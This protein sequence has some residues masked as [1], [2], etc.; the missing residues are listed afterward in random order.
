MVDIP[1][2]HSTAEKED[3]PSEAYMAHLGF[4]SWQT[5]PCRSRLHFFSSY[6]S[7]KMGDMPHTFAVTRAGFTSFKLELIWGAM[8]VCCLCCFKFHV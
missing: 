3:Q 4:W 8:E 5:M 1:T 2:T 7:P 6:L